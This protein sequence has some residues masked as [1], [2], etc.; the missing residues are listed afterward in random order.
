M[1]LWVDVVV[2]VVHRRRIVVAEEPVGQQRLVR[3]LV[4]V[5]HD[6]DC[7]GV[8][9]IVFGY[10]L[11]GDVVRC[12]AGVADLDRHHVWSLVYDLLHVLEAAVGDDRD[13]AWIGRIDPMGGFVFCFVG[14]VVGVFIFCFVALDRRLGDWCGRR[15]GGF[16]VYV[17]C[18]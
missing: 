5:E 2:L 8:V 13:L 11:V 14:E 4:G 15:V 9:G 1:V 17:Y 7:F 16:V 6:L 10:L 12:V 3:D 18:G